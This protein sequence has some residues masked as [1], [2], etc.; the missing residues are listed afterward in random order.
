MPVPSKAISPALA[1]EGPHRSAGHGRFPR[2]RDGAAAQDVHENSKLTIAATNSMI[3]EPVVVDLKNWRKEG[4]PSE[5]AYAQAMG[6]L[7]DKESSPIHGKGRGKGV[8][9]MSDMFFGEGRGAKQENGNERVSLSNSDIAKSSA[10]ARRATAINNRQ[11]FDIFGAA[12][13]RG[14]EGG[15]QDGSQARA[16]TQVH[17]ELGHQAQPDKDS[18]QRR[19]R[20]QKK[21]TESS[22]D[23]G[24]SPWATDASSSELAAAFDDIE[25][26]LTSLMAE[27]TSLRN[28]SEKLH[29]RGAKTLKDRTSLV[30]VEM[31]LTEVDKEISA[32]RKSLLAR[33][34]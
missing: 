6:V 11:H 27:R 22:V 34:L 4:Y 8:M 18:E 1:C 23:I 12:P 32:A 25:K 2:C 31:R 9:T 19:L 33:P 16:Q 30:K 5:Y 21:G 3:A 20:S 15:S 29:N 17:S 10:E 28:E 24:H 13:I 7:R 26:K 14:G